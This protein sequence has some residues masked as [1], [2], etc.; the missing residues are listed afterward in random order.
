MKKAQEDNNCDI[1]ENNE[2]LDAC[3]ELNR[4]ELKMSEL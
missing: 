3:A 1:S 2:Y 4:I